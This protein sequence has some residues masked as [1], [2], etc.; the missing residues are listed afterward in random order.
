MRA[1]FLI[2]KKSL[3]QHAFATCITLLS[4]ALASGLMLSVFNIKTQSRQAFL[5]DH[6]G[7]D[8]VLGT[9]GSDLQLVL[10]SVYHLETS[11]G[12]LPWSL[13]KTIKRHMGVKLAV[14]YALGDNYHGFRIIGTTTDL[15]DK[16]KFKDGKAYTFKQGKRFEPDAMEAVVGSYVAES[17]NL[18]VGDKIHPYH[19]LIFDEKAKHDQTY[20]ISGIL[21]PTNTPNDRVLWIPIDLFFRMEGHVLR[22][23]GKEFTP[24][25]G[26]EIP[27][28]HKEVSAVMLQLR[29]PM[30]GL[31]LNQ[32]INRQGKEAT[33]AYPIARVIL[34]FFNKM[35]WV[36]QILELVAILTLVVAATGVLASLYNTL[37]ERRKS[38]L[39]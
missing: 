26:Q 3:I 32:M 15:F 22:G 39:F 24:K 33:F 8:A 21:E 7:F 36:V 28:E 27:D 12:N 4:V 34:E 31:M 30:S 19:G 18:K 5:V 17:L 37:H 35:G 10:N 25:A 2:I 9:R 23:S 14:P 38:L 20:I 11:Q 13:Y 1:I 16:F 6:I 29:N